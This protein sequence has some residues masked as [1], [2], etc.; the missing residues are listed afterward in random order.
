MWCVCQHQWCLWLQNSHLAKS[1]L[2]NDVNHFRFE[3]QRI[4]FWQRRRVWV[5]KPKPHLLLKSLIPTIY[6]SFLLLAQVKYSLPVYKFWFSSTEFISYVFF[7][8]FIGI[9]GQEQE[10]SIVTKKGVE[11]RNY[12]G[13]SNPKTIFI[14]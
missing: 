7:C 11:A 9:R 1:S 6:A 4:L 13:V 5:L 10:V 2:F 14:F 8:R 3:T 12:E